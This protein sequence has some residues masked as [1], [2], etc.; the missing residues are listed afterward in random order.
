MK[1]MNLTFVFPLQTIFFREWE[2]ILSLKLRYVHASFHYNVKIFYLS[3]DEKFHSQFDTLNFLEYVMESESIDCYS[4]S[5]Y[6]YYTSQYFVEYFFFFLFSCIVNP[7][8]IFT[9]FSKF[10]KLNEFKKLNE[11]LCN[12]SSVFLESQNMSNIWMH[13]KVV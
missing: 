3:F 11:K 12:S 7:N 1:N 8:V 10:N 5:Y 6:A 4:N 2:L 13:A 9:N